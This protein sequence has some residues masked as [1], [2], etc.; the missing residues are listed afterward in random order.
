MVRA[1]LGESSFP[2]YQ[3]SEG[4]EVKDQAWEKGTVLSWI[5]TCAQRQKRG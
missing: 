5:T 1:L 4:D 3:L 2:V